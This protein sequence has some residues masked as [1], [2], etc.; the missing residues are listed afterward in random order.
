MCGPIVAALSFSKPGREHGVFFHLFYNAGRLTTYVGIGVI[1]GWAGSLLNTTTTFIFLSQG[2]LILADMFVIMIG[3]RTS[4]LFKQ[5]TFIHLEI[6]GSVKFM[7]KG[8]TQLQKLPTVAAAFPVGL[9]MGF[10]PCGFLYAIALAAAGRGNPVTGGLIM[11]AFGLGTLP[12]LFLF[13]SLVLWLSAS[14]R[15]ELLR[16]AGLMVVSIGCYNLYQHIQ[17]SGWVG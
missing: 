8:V 4:G 5:L 12:A 11:F 13:G 17:A 9:I 6:P 16:W 3:L 14:I 2:I 7:T 1:A 10:L 15:T